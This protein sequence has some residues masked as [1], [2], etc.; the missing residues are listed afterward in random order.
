MTCGRCACYLIDAQIF[1][2]MRFEANGVRLVTERF[3]GPQLFLL[4]G[5]TVGVD[6]KAESFRRQVLEGRIDQTDHPRRISSAGA[7]AVAVRVTVLTSHF[8]S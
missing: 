4:E 3:H 6:L 5:H 1:V 2:Q 8:Q 7:V